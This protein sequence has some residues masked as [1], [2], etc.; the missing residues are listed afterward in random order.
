V[1]FYR[2]LDDLTEAER[3]IVISICALADQLPNDIE[4]YRSV[5]S[6]VRQYYFNKPGRSR[7][8]QPKGFLEEHEPRVRKRWQ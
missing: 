6:W 1:A 3:L 7:G 4:T 2:K 8:E 5:I